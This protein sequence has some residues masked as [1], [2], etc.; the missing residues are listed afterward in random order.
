MQ[1]L[2]PCWICR[3][4]KRV[5]AA[6]NI[7]HRLTKREAGLE[8]GYL[9]SVVDNDLVIN[10]RPDFLCAVEN[11]HTPTVVVIQPLD[12]ADI[13][14]V[15]RHGAVNYLFHVLSREIP[16]GSVDT[17]PAVIVVFRHVF[18][19]SSMSRSALHRLQ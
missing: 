14:I 13:R 1:A 10:F 19:F 18:P 3:V 5:L 8:V 4:V 6:I 7:L 9:G 12:I 17:P 2:C 11:V 15:R 16:L